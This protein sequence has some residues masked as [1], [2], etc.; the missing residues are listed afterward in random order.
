MTSAACAIQQSRL[1][2]SA[3]AAQ[4]ADSPT[5]TALVET[6]AI[7]Q[8]RLHDVGFSQ[9]FHKLYTLGEKIGRGAEG[10]VFIGESR[11]SGER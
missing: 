6:D 8:L 10:E 2:C 5:E 11:R 3:A 9:D 4:Q 1:L 7:Q